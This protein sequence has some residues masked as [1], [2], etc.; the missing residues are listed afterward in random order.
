MGKN[1]GAQRRPT[2]T[3][4]TVRGTCTE[5]RT[6]QESLWKS[7]SHPTTLTPP[8]TPPL[9]LQTLTTLTLSSIRTLAP[10]LLTGL[11]FPPFFRFGSV[12]FL[13]MSEMCSSWELR[14]LGLGEPKQREQDKHCFVLGADFKQETMRPVKER[15]FFDIGWPQKS[16][17]GSWMGLDHNSSSQGSSSSCS[18]T[19]LSI[20]IPMGLHDFPQWSVSLFFT[21]V[22]LFHCFAFSYIK[23]LYAVLLQMMEAWD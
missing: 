5:A 16:K 18:K 17:E 13:L 9:T 12:S 20:S 8:I 15:D 11:Y 3:P 6:V 22:Q 7:L 4:S 21:C 2:Q 19:Q 14:P 1:G 10:L 23:V